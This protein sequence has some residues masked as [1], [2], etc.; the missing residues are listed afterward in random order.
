MVVRTKIT[1]KVVMPAKCISKILC[2]SVSKHTEEQI[3]PPK[4]HSGR[5]N[6]LR[7]EESPFFVQTSPL[8]RPFSPHLVAAGQGSET[9]WTTSTLPT[10]PG[11]LLGPKRRAWAL[12]QFSLSC[13]YE[14][15]VPGEA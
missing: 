11:E 13:L 6:L 7:K 15:L 8:G 2:L 10:S 5:E 1:G 12:G 14:T 4:Q 9:A 3:L